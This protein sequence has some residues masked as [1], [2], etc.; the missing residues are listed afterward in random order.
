MNAVTQRKIDRVTKGL[1]AL[2]E[3]GI[4]P[5]LMRSKY[6]FDLVLVDESVKGTTKDWIV[7]DLA[8]GLDY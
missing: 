6:G 8:E 2:S 3:K 4:V 1:K 5:A 7:A